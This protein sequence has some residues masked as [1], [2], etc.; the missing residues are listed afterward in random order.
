MIQIENQKKNVKQREI[1][2]EKKDEKHTYDLNR[3]NQ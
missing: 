3:I 2:G 1:Q